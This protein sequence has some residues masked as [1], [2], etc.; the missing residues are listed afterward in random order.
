MPCR[1]RGCP[2]RQAPV[3]TRVLTAPH[4]QALNYAHAAAAVRTC[5]YKLKAPVTREQL[6]LVCVQLGCREGR[7]VDRR[8]ALRGSRKSFF[9][10][11]AKCCS[12]AAVCTQVGGFTAG[13]ISDLVETGTCA[14]LEQFRRGG[15][16]HML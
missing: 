5:A 9:L 7:R 6:P 10:G 15:W 11:A 3:A 16:W 2:S 13:L 1:R 12:A 8:V 14:P 4:P